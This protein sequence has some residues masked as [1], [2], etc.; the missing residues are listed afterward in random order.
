MFAQRAPTACT[1]MAGASWC[2][3]TSNRWAG[4]RRGAPTNESTSKARCCQKEAMCQAAPLACATIENGCT[5]RRPGAPRSG[6]PRA[7]DQSRAHLEISEV[8]L[9]STSQ[10]TH[11]SHTRIPNVHTLV[12]PKSEPR[13]RTK[14]RPTSHNPTRRNMSSERF[15][16]NRIAMT[17]NGC[18]RTCAMRAI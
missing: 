14:C 12:A 18:T 11:N 13:K 3:R 1:R 10:N 8:R 5:M 17:I 4:G 16:G 7:T 6:D 9:H 15:L 2:R